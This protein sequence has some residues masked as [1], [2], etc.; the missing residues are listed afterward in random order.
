M[1][2]FLKIPYLLFLFICIMRKVLI[3]NKDFE[4]RKKTIMSVSYSSDRHNWNFRRQKFRTLMRGFLGVI[5]ETMLVVEPNIRIEASSA[6]FC[7]FPTFFPMHFYF[8][9]LEMKCIFY[10]T[11]NV[12]IALFLTI[13]FVI[14]KFSPF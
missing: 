11:I 13:C 2:A 7:S 1:L 4:K 12:F 9:R 6:G 14:P 5:E 3:V 8:C 10:H